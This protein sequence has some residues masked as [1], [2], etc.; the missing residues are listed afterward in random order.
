MG[1]NDK[2]LAQFEAELRG[3]LAA[4]R[5]RVHRESATFQEYLDVEAALRVID[6]SGTSA[7]RLGKRGRTRTTEFVTATRKIMEE[8][9]RPIPVGELRSALQDQGIE[10]ALRNLSSRLS[11]NEMFAPQNGEGWV[12]AEGQSE[13]APDDE[14]DP[15]PSPENGEPI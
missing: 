3:R 11:T 5:S 9:G 4:L 15:S 10:I 7:S 1:D 14:T 12:L 8:H 13:T 6:R 2:S